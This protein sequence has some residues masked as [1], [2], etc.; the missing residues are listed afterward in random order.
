M[1]VVGVPMGDADPVEPGAEIV[2]HLANQVA[3][4]G[5]VTETMR[6]FLARRPRV[7]ISPR[8]SPS[9]MRSKV[10]MVAMWF[11]PGCPSP[12]PPRSQWRSRGRR[13]STTHPSWPERS[14]GWRCR[15]FLVSARNGRSPGEESRGVAIAARRSRRSRPVARSRIDE[16]ASSR[17]RRPAGKVMRPWDHARAGLAEREIANLAHGKTPRIPEP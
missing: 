8:Y 12:R 5:L 2:L 4:E 14:A 11:L 10:P 13:R 6:T 16:T 15:D 17:A 7:K 1:R 3:G 9:P